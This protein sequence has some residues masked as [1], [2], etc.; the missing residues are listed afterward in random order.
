MI[1][2]AFKQGIGFTYLLELLFLLLV[3]GKVVVDSFISEMGWGDHHHC[4]IDFVRD[5]VPK[6]PDTPWS[7]SI[8]H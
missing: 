8:S 4:I 6:T 3:K 1:G 2:F 5:V 7:T